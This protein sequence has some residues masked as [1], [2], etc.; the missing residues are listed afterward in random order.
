MTH[1]LAMTPPMGWNSWNTFGEKINEQVVL[2]TADLFVKLGLKDAGYE[3]IVIDD[4]WSL[5]ERDP[6]TNEIVPDPVKFPRG[7]KFVS[8]YIH[9]KG[10]KFGMYSCAGTR[11]CAN[12]PSSFGH[13]FLDART[14]AKWGVDFLKYDYCNMPFG[15]QAPLFYR[16]MG[17]ALRN[18]GREI[19]FSACEWGAED[20]W[21]WIR[22]TGASMYR[23]TG[24]IFDNFESMKKIAQSQLPKLASSAPGC[25]N[26]MDMLT[27]GMFG[28]GNVG[29]AES[30][31]TI[32]QYK[33]QFAVWCVWGSPLMLGCDIRKLADM[34]D[35]LALVTNKDLLRIN[36][37]PLGRQAYAADTCWGNQDVGTV[38]RLLDNNET[39][40]LCHNFTDADRT[41][42]CLLEKLGISYESG[43]KLR[44]KDCFTGKTAFS[45]RDEFSVS[46][47]A[48]SCRVF[49]CKPVKA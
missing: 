12:Y 14:F 24:D 20:V 16:R 17:Q 37:D 25:W 31:Q 28:L 7:M 35:V 8:D 46:V 3:Y 32:D 11:T 30:V 18:S 47:P 36:Q 15:G 45:G 2:E 29:S 26:D 10:L 38:A 6:K 21:S 44:M 33:L 19:L 49:L 9:K 41:F 23:S 43:L 4:C 5:R 40:V 13:E 34:P 39:A 42:H 1:P 22:S 48:K 27:V